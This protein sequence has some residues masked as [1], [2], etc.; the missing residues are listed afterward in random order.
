MQ[1]NESPHAKSPNVR[2]L[3]C[4][5]RNTRADKTNVKNIHEI[6]YRERMIQLED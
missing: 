4:R 5:T 6:M 3:Y 1:E 2:S